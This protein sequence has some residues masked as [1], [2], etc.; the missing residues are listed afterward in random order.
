MSDELLKLARYVETE[1]GL[2]EKERSTIATALR[3][4]ATCR[5]GE[6]AFADAEWASRY[7]AAVIA[8]D[9]TIA[10]LE[11][12]VKAQRE[13]IERIVTGSDVEAVSAENSELRAR[14]AELEAE[15][16][17]NADALSLYDEAVKKLA[18]AEADRDGFKAA[19]RRCQERCRELEKI[20]RGRDDPYREFGK[21]YDD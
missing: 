11:E 1:A 21:R 8:R 9:Q 4:H 17:G 2:T 14:I 15:A 10:K 5:P 12:D 16:M 3:E 13:E 18:K 6:R 20:C 19:L 7:N